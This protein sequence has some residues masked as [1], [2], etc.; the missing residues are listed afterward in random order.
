MVAI[1][2]A[3]KSIYLTTGFFVPPPDLVDALQA[4]ARRGVDVELIVPG[5]STSD[6]SLKAGRSYYEE[7]MDTGVKIYERKNAILHAKTAV[8]DGVWS[9]V[10]SSNLDWRS[11]LFNNEC[12]AVVFWVKVFGGQMEAI[13]RQDVEESNYIDPAVLARESVPFW[14]A[15]DEWKARLVEYPLVIKFI[16]PLREAI[17]FRIA[18]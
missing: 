6:S 14:E 9:T 1:A 13:F 16:S 11:V 10:G 5:E 2:L 8:I 15:L 4:A 12:N 7:L 17:C 3:H 18:D